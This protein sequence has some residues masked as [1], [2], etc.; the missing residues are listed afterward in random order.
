MVIVL[1]LAARRRQLKGRER[2]EYAEESCHVFPVSFPPSP[3]ARLRLPNF[4]MDLRTLA[5][6]IFTMINITLT[7]YLTEI[8]N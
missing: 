7:K 2:E 1:T 6:L 5:R 4:Y 3:R 8:P